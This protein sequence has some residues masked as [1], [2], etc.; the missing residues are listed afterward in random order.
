[1]ASAITLVILVLW[2]ALIAQAA[3]VV[4]QGLRW[5]RGPMPDEA[6]PFRRGRKVRH[7]SGRS[8]R[9]ARRTRRRAEGPVSARAAA[10][11]PR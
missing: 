1:M 3:G 5:R 2:A 10:P 11:A 4:W 6:E 7:G 9:Q 8:P